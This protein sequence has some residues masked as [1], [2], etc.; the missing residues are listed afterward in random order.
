MN[1]PFITN[2]D[3]LSAFNTHDTIRDI[4]P[5]GNEGSLNGNGNISRPMYM[6]KKGGAVE[7]DLLNQEWGSVEELIEAEKAQLGGGYGFGTTLQHVGHGHHPEVQQTMSCAQLGGGSLANV[8]S[9]YVLVPHT[10]PEFP[11]EGTASENGVPYHG[12][13]LEHKGANLIDFAGSYAPITAGVHAGGTK[14]RRK[15]RKTNKKMRGGKRLKKH[16]KTKKQRRRR[17]NK[18]RSIRGGYHQYG[19]NTTGPSGYSPVLDG[20][21][22]ESAPH[23]VN[24]HAGN[25]VDNYNHF[26]GQGA[27]SPILD[28]DVQMPLPVEAPV[29]ASLVAEGGGK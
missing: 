26:T 29:G 11:M 3:Q 8:S 12:F 28:Q 1:S 21:S 25:A 16:N 24:P 10:K 15:H 22:A 18:R 7:R 2:N 6:D 14:R 17:H 27:L 5:Y 23:H 13:G 9:P 4:G 20:V 19:S